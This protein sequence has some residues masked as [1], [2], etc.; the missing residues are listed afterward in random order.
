MRTYLCVCV[1][2][3]V[4]VCVCV[5]ACA[6][7]CVC[8]CMCVCGC[9]CM[10]CY[11]RRTSWPAWRCPGIHA[12]HLTLL[13]LSR[14]AITQPR[15]EL[16]PPMRN[17]AFL[18]NVLASTKRPFWIETNAPVE[19]HYSG[20]R[21]LCS[22]FFVWKNKITRL[23]DSLQIFRRAL[24]WSH[25]FPTVWMRSLAQ[26]I[27][28]FWAPGSLCHSFSVGSGGKLRIKSIHKGREDPVED[29]C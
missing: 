24:L 8:V 11:Y 18:W 20:F 4:C 15:D 9:V 16:C 1:R 2:V 10:C 28:G 3:C 13:E 5:R 21:F 17:I 12:P 29:C 25:L 19:Q 14:F 26:K 6:R 27:M 23:S 7:I 22:F